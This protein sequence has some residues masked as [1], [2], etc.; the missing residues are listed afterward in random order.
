MNRNLEGKARTELGNKIFPDQRE[1]KQV[2]AF[3]NTCYPNKD[4]SYFGRE[5]KGG[6][7]EEKG[8][9]RKGKEGRGGGARRED[10]F[11]FEYI[12]EEIK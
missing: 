8:K 5:G 3:P 12:L 4:K 6:G 7:R 10:L 9:E 1:K 2:K 11:C